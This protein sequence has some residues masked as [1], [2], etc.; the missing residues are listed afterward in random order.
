M[1]K[2]LISLLLI[3][4]CVVWAVAQPLYRGDKLLHGFDRKVEGNDFS[5]YYPISGITKNLIVRPNSG[6]SATWL[7]EAVPT[8]IK[9][10]K[11]VNFVWPVAIGSNGQQV[12]FSLWVNGTK[13]FD[14]DSR[15]NENWSVAGA[16]GS[17][18]SYKNIAFDN[19]RDMKGLMYLRMPV[20]GLTPGE[21][22]ELKVTTPKGD[23][24]TWFM[25]YQAA[26][27]PDIKARLLPSVVRSKGVPMQQLFVDIMHFAPDQSAVIRLDGKLIGKQNVR[28]GHNTLS[29]PIAKVDAE[30]TAELTVTTSE[31]VNRQQVTLKPTKNWRVNFVQHSHTDIGYTRSQTEILGE[32]I[33]YI[34]YALDY[35]DL[36]DSYPDDA[37]FRWT[38]EAAWAVEEYLKTRPAEQIERLKRRVKEGRIEL[39]G[40]LFN[41]DEM[42]DEQ[43]L[44]ASLI[45][46]KTLRKEGLPVE[47]AMQNDVNGIGW[48]FADYFPDLGIKYLNM[49]THGHRAL[50]CFDMPTLFRWESPSGK[51]TLAYR[52]E[53]Y[54]M[55]NFLGVETGNFEQFEVK[56]LE[57]LATLESKN[58]PMDIAAV[59]YSGYFTDN[60]P[61]SI[62]SSDMIRKWNEKY[63]SPKLRA[64]VSTEFFK[65]AEARYASQIETIRG[66]WP[67]WW[68][69]GFGAGAREVAVSRNTHTDLI[70]ARTA[71]AMANLQG[72]VMPEDINRD[73]DQANRALLFYDEHT[74]GS[75]ESVRDPYARASIDQRALKESYAWEAFRRT[76]IASE[77]A[78][79]QL[80][81]Y[82]QKASVPSIVVYNPLNW[83]RSGVI[84][85]Y[86][87]HEILPR[88]RQF[89]I[90]TLDGRK[91]AA[92]PRDSRSDGTYWSIWVDD[93]PALGSTQLLIKTS[94]TPLNAAV[95]E[96][97]LPQG[98]V[99]E[100]Q[101][102]RMEIDP[103]RGTIK[104]LLDKDLNKEIIDPAA[105]WQLGEIIYEQLE[106]RSSMEA[107]R[108]A[109]GTRIAPETL[110]FAECR[111]G[112]IYDT[113][114]F[115]GNTIAG[116]ELPKRPN[117]RV[118]IR[119][120]HTTKQIELA[121]SL[122]KK[123]VI[124]PEGIYV[125]LPF[126]LDDSKIY[127][128]VQGG[129]MQAGV[130]QIKGS[131]N[132]WNTMQNFVA[133][134]SPK[135]QIVVTSNEVPLMQ[136]GAINTGRYKAGAVPES[137]KIY[138]WPMNNY[139]VTNFNADQRGEFQWSYLITSMDSPSNGAATQFGWGRRVPLL[140]RILPASAQSSG[141]EPKPFGSLLSL[142]ADNLLL[143]GAVPVEGERAIMLQIREIEGQA[144]DMKLTSS[145]VQTPVIEVCDALGAPLLSAKTNFTPY[146]VKFVK[147]SW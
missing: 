90:V 4:T 145:A 38:C 56:L 65:D 113:Y 125:S 138:S 74:T 96:K 79:G 120:Y 128:E 32:H 7:T 57:Y 103:A 78:Q 93:V 97:S 102:Y 44:A 29:V 58:Y 14:F 27:T 46:L 119:M 62:A 67:D 144:A 87:D 35:C 39:T 73:I 81:T 43:T 104:R 109:K 86:I 100:N 50:I 118:E 49:G 123:P 24:S 133:V 42:P 83:S 95:S 12:E 23:A 16:D 64:A 17:S 34:D 147:M 54:N 68:T 22:I 94:A 19:N 88:G 146:E 77:T 75:S 8:D 135:A 99:V 82:V 108:A 116:I 105:E 13:M 141:S 59:Q 134:R 111:R 98:G 69:D 143:V 130:D 127:C 136:F 122:F 61:P 129:V 107:Y 18:L 48:C 3:V 25:T 101:W 55:G 10:A 84:D 89:E 112:E 66:A 63:E 37:K 91:V 142:G 70:A 124:T 30:R 20:A 9:G 21:G 80:Q 51:Q 1:K 114:I 71:L 132:D 41:F 117:L 121:Y 76:R 137:S 28:L 92:Q 106:D 2:T 45:P 72:A 36:T 110:K 33:R 53:H 15:A 139:W 40:M 115:T 52:A 31:G 85:A 6:Q 26:L 5:Y 140:N 60:S 131:S 47:I 11:M 126:Q